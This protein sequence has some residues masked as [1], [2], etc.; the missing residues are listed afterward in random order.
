MLPSLLVH[1]S[2]AAFFLYTGSSRS[3]PADL[4]R[5]VTRQRHVRAGTRFCNCSCSS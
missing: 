1:H 4:A 5:A 2:S 3:L